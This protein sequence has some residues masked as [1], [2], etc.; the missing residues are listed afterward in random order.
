MTPAVVQVPRHLWSAFHFYHV[1][2]PHCASTSRR[3]WRLGEACLAGRR[4]HLC[5]GKLLPFVR[6]RLRKEQVVLLVSR[7]GTARLLASHLH[8]IAESLEVVIV[9]AHLHLNLLELVSHR[10][11]GLQQLMELLRELRRAVRLGCELLHPVL[12]ILDLSLVLLRLLHAR[13]LKWWR[14][15]DVRERRSGV[16]H[17]I[18][19]PLLLECETH[20]RHQ[21]VARRHWRCHGC[22]PEWLRDHG[23]GLRVDQRCRNSIRS[24]HRWGLGHRC[25]DS[26]CD[27][28]GC[29][30]G[31]R[32]RQGWSADTQP[33]AVHPSSRAGLRLG[34]HGSGREA[35]RGRA[36]LRR[37]HLGSLRPTRAHNR[38]DN[39]RGHFDSRHDG[40]RLHPI[41]RTIGRC[42][43]VHC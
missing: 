17:A 18:V 6:R 11:L 31:S 43:H 37:S 2:V 1:L 26:R 39:R 34:G 9:G 12:V 24:G 40:L 22:C 36:E 7:R 32:Q 19:V 3:T 30:N 15:V 38:G 25:D 5:M 29:H 27:L 13:R 23:N 4:C 21:R 8:L 35:C 16:I 42:R 10:M 33:R 14:H 20:G 41:A 28:H